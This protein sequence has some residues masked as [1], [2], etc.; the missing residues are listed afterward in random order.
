[1]TSSTVIAQLHLNAFEERQREGTEQPG[2]G[3]FAMGRGRRA[4]QSRVV[5]RDR[6]PH[7]DDDGRQDIAGGEPQQQGEREPYVAAALKGDRPAVQIVT[8]PALSR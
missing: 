1:M 5:R 8:A 7:P 6:Q 4:S 3:A 2:P